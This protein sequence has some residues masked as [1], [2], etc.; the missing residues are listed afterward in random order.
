MGLTYTKTQLAL[1]ELAS[2]LRL[3]G[4]ERSADALA[5]IADQ[6]S[7]N[8]RLTNMLNDPAGV[9]RVR[10]KAERSALDFPRSAASGTRYV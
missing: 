1:W 7:V 10:E 3:E 5:V 4:D 2:A 6:P 9:D 8:M